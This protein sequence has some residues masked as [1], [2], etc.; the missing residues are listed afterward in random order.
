MIQKKLLLLAI[1][2]VMLVGCYD[3]YDESPQES[4]RARQRAASEVAMVQRADGPSAGAYKMAESVDASTQGNS[5][6]AER[7]IAEAQRWV[8]EVDAQQLEQVWLAHRDICLA[9][10]KDCEITEATLRN[11]GPGEGASYASME[12]RVARPSFDRFLT[13][14]A[15]TGPAPIE[16]VLS[17]EDKTLVWVDL[18]ARLDNAVQLRDRLQAMVSQADRQHDL[19]DLLAI[20]REL[21]RV[22]STIDSMTA[23]SIVLAQI[24]D[25]ISLDFEYHSA[26]TTVARDI[27]DPIRHAWHNFTS[28]FARNVGEVILFAAAAIPWIVVLIPAWIFGRWALRKIFAR[29]LKRP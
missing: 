23:Q 4:A 1:A 15:E 2:A 8:F 21:S 25:N 13:K 9:M 18:Q 3:S 11:N 27:W 20:E 26:P 29:W 16:T 6:I 17:R 24:T 5:E 12:M 28:T 22:Q 10:G 7:R 19:A 14:I